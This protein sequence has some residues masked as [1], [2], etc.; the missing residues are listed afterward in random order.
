M[1]GSHVLDPAQINR[2]VDVILFVDVGRQDRHRNFK[3][4]RRAQISVFKRK[5][6]ISSSRISI[7]SAGCNRLRS[8]SRSLGSMAAKSRTIFSRVLYLEYLPQP[9]PIAIKADTVQTVISVPVITSELQIR[10][11]KVGSRKRAPPTFV[12]LNPIQMCFLSP[13][14][15]GSDF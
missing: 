6:F 7:C 8:F 3:C 9:M 13:M 12:D 4:G 5:R 10:N 11:Y 14:P 15:A 2:V 1:R